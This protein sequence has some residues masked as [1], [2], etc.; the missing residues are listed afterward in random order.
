W[1]TLQNLYGDWANLLEYSLYFLLGAA[2]WR[3]PAIEAA[4]C[5]TWRGAGILLAGTTS[6]LVVFLLREAF[7]PRAEMILITLS[8]WLGTTFLLGAAHH[9][10]R[11][12][13][14]PALAYLR[15]ASFP[16]YLVH[17]VV[18]VALAFWMVRLPV[19]LMT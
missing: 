12:A 11:N 5:R 13:D 7:P 17:M 2:L 14:G 3:Y 15:E 10:C 6:L 1:P 16:I 9:F 8:G 19:P 18:L 4:L